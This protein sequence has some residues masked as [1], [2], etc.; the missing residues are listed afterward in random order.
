MDI[1]EA[2]ITGKNKQS[3]WVGKYS[4][5]QSLQEEDILDGEGEATSQLPH[6][7]EAGDMLEAPIPVL[8][9]TWK[10]SG[11]M[12]CRKSQHRVLYKMLK[13]KSYR[14]IHTYVGSKFKV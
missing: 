14:T 13:T 9:R 1:N 2:R 11:D 6:R 7:N 10:L 4:G 5:K 8:Q 12:R 3:G